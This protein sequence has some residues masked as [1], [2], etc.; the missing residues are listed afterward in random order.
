[1]NDCVGIIN[2]DENESRMGELTRNRLLA[3]VPIAAR[4]RIVDFVLSNMTNSEI[5]RIGIFTKN[6]SKSLINHLSNGRPWDLHRKKDGLKVFNFGNEDPVYDDIHNFFENIEFVKTSRR[7]Y[8]LISPAYM[9][10]NIDYQKAINEHK[11][12]KNDITIIYKNVNTADREFLDCDVLNIDEN[13]QVLSIGRN[14][15]KDTNVANISMEM[16]VMS[17]ELFIDI[18]LESVRSGMYRKIKQ[19][20]SSNLNN[21]KVG[22]YEFQ[23]YLSCINS[24]KSYYDFNMDLLNEKI[25]MELFSGKRPIYTKI[26]DEAPVHYSKDSNVTNSII[27]NGCIIEGQVNNSVVSRRVYVAER[28]KVQDCIIMQNTVIG[29][30]ARLEKVIADRE[31]EIRKGEVY[32]GSKEWPV[33]MNNFN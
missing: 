3:S 31:T 27:A 20:I 17:T 23:G 21:I 33:V 24:L 6:K 15:G 5:E 11:N 30:G 8:V 16:Y 22:T 9:L 32:K 18:V 25:N 19:Y 12:N 7:D 26:K 10:C 2:L 29:E 1:M 14:I 13:G 28:A 4:Y